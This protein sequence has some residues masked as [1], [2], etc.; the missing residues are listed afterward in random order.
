MFISQLKNTCT[1][2]LLQALKSLLKYVFFI[3]I[4]HKNEKQPLSISLV[5]MA[6]SVT[7]WLSLASPLLN[8]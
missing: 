8:R 1:F 7:L 5:N 2:A 6:P 3:L 4:K